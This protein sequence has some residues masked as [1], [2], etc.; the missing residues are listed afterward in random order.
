MSL[1]I[2][3]AKI[4]EWPGSLRISPNISWVKITLGCGIVV[5]S[6]L[7]GQG[8]GIPMTLDNCRT[9]WIKFFYCARLLGALATPQSITAFEVSDVGVI[10]TT[11]AC[12]N[13]PTSPFK[14][15]RQV[16]IGFIFAFDH[17]EDRSF[18]NEP[19]SPLL[20]PCFHMHFDIMHVRYSTPNLK[21][22]KYN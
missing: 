18:Q 6:T 10:H 1:P 17:G 15:E 4:Q 14:P 20:M 7:L 12:G 2:V 22:I 8:N 5:V 3:F 21:E 13:V 19:S 11:P 16:N 9:I